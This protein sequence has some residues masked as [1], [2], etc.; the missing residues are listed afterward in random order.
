VATNAVTTTHNGNSQ[1][2][3][4]PASSAAAEGQ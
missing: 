3:M 4:K 2:R 1:K